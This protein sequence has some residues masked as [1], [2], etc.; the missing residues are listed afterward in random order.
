MQKW[1][2]EE[3]QRPVI[4]CPFHFVLIH[5]RR[6]GQA[7]L[8]DTDADRPHRWDDDRHISIELS[9]NMTM[10]GTSRAAPHATSFVVSGALH[11]RAAI[12]KSIESQGGLELE[13][14]RE[15]SSL[16]IECIQTKRLA[17]SDSSISGCT[18]PLLTAFSWAWECWLRC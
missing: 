14:Y 18:F 10:H 3:A 13:K 1:Q 15:N 12:K 2:E 4:S 8:K 5:M 11:S 6:S 17:Q 16:A 9:E 7:T